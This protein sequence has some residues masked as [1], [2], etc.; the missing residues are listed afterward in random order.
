MSIGEKIREIRKRQKLTLKTVSEETGLSI[1]FLSQ[2]ETNKCNATMASLRNI[3]DALNVHP[4]LLFEYEEVEGHTTEQHQ[5]FQYFN[6]ANH[7]HAV[8]TPLKVVIAPGQERA[9]TV[10]HSGH[11]FVYCLKGT[12][13]LLVGEV[14]YQI[15]EGQS[16]MYIASQPHY[17][18]NYTDQPVEFLVVNET[19]NIKHNELSKEE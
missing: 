10:S 2:L 8:F 12:L 3:A 11:E 15:G 14:Q 1:A 18:F 19:E 16:L 13:T 5:S 17:W 9:D 7:E 6:L 4:S